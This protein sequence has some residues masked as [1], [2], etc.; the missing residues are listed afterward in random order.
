MT[1]IIPAILTDDNQK[2]Q[3]LIKQSEGVVDRVQIDIIDAVFAD[4]KTIRPDSLI[5]I[6]TNLF[7]DYHLMVKEPI[8]WVEASIRGFADRIIGQVEMM[9][10][11]SAFIEKVQTSG[12]RAGLAID[13]DTKVS[14]MERN[15]LTDLDL[16]IVMSVKAGFGGQRF[17]EKTLDKIKELAFW[18]EKEETPFKICIDGGVNM[19]NIVKI[20]KAG[21]DEVSIGRR[22]F[23]N[24]MEET[25]NEYYNRLGEKYE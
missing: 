6:E 12:A 1:K 5:D 24:N 11:Q 9:S 8:N 17:Q 14:E 25:L 20:K 18:R 10:S 23:T 7:F 21:A 4:N 2:L 16:V 13:I 15:I 19:D 3:D 22:L